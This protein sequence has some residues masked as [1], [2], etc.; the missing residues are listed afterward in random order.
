MNTRAIILG[1]GQSWDDSGLAAVRAL[2]L[3]PVV[4]VPLIG[5]TIRWLADAGVTDVTICTHQSWRV[6]PEMLPADLRNRV[7]LTH[8][9]DASPRGTAGCLRDAVEQFGGDRLIVCDGTILPEQDLP[10]IIEHHVDEAAALT[11]VVAEDSRSDPLVAARSRPL[12]IYVVDR[13]AVERIPARGYQDLKEMLIPRLYAE[14]LQTTTWTTSRAALRLHDVNSYLV[15]SASAIT[16]LCRQDEAPAGYSKRNQSLIHE[17]ARVAAD[18]ALIGP[19]VIGPNCTVEKNVTI[20][21]PTILGASCRIAATAVICA[22]VLWD[23]C[24]AEQR[25]VIDHAVVIDDGY[26]PNGARVDHTIFGGDSI[27]SRLRTG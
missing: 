10:R 9:V 2:P 21:G 3:M 13:D 27:Y 20:I 18:A 19:V 11:V 16:K 1:G 26:V 15:M 7:N 24:R 22:S 5:H 4:H 23:R 6:T 8:Y 17:T 14:G 12:G 25:S